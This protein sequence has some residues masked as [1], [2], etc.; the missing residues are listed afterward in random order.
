MKLV[1]MKISDNDSEKMV[2]IET[3]RLI[4]REYKESDWKAVHLYGQQENILIYE[5]WGP[6]SEEQTKAF[7]EKSINE[8]KENPRKAFELCVTLKY[9]GKLIGGCGFRIKKEN[10]I[11]GDFGYIINP[12][13]WN[14][15][16]ATEASKG[17]LDYMI[18]QY[19][20]TEIE[21]TCDILNLQSQRVLEKCGL[22]KIKEIKN[23]IEM[24][25]RFRDTYLYERI[26]K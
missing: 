1:N 21:A 23:E 2:K 17:L 5:A 16:F 24:K 4:L 19:N 22:Q 8:R 14:K 10:R 12:D 9:D 15:G 25:G 20:I 3:K 6:N 18:K 7:I 26:I 13:F 11:R